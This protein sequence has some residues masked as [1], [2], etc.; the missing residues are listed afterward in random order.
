M[1][2]TGTTQQ[3]SNYTVRYSSTV[4]M[5]VVMKKNPMTVVMKKN[6]MTVVM[7]KNP[8]TVP[9]RWLRSEGYGTI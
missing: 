4:V 9:E 7:K 8:M 1:Q 5:T 6:P 3:Y 2:V